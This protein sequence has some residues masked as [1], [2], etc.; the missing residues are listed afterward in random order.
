[1]ASIIELEK[2]LLQLSPAERA[3]IALAAWESLAQ[4]PD[5]AADPD[6]DPHGLDLAEARDQQLNLGTSPLGI[7]EFRRRTGGE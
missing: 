1:M 3:R 7:E 5:A 6:L 4:D 2:E